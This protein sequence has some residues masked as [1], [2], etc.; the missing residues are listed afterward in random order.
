MSIYWD[1]RFVY[2]NGVKVSLEFK[3]TEH[4]SLVDLKYILENLFE[5]S[6]NR[7]VV[8]LKYSSPSID[9]DRKIQRNSLKLKTN[10]DLRVMW[11]I[12]H[13]FETKGMIPI[14]VDMKIVRSTIDILKMLQRSAE[15]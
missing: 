1:V 15:I 9:N 3:V 11:S 5:Y 8:K 6:N 12:F 14:E 2:F 7:K 4:T 13:C 10:E